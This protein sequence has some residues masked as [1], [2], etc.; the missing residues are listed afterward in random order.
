MNKD[1]KLCEY[2][3]SK[4]YTYEDEVPKNTRVCTDEDC[5][6]CEDECEEP[7][8]LITENEGEDT[9]KEKFCE[10]KCPLCRSANIDWKCSEDVADYY[11]E[12]PG[13]CLECGCQFK[14][15]REIVYKSTIIGE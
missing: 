10:N 3:M 15:I 5:T 4:F 7:I 12:Q 9:E 6:K 1:R 11:Q 13:K 2:P 14:E 8:C